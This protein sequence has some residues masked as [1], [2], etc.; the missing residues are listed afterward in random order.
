MK[1][2]ILLL[3]TIISL[4]TVSCGTSKVAEVTKPTDVKTP[5]ESV[6]PMP[7][8]MAIPDGI[9]ANLLVSFSR[10]ACFG[11]CPAYEV[12]VFED[13]TATYV[14]KGFVTDRKSVV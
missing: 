13:G 11:K 1:T 12:K 8:P 10:G 4:I 2:S 9:E 6:P 14:G 5:M 7:K 3:A